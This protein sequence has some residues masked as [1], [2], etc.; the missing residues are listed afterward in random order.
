MIET[1]NNGNQ[2]YAVTQNYG[3]P[4]HDGNP[5]GVVN[6]NQFLQNFDASGIVD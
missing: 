2:L 5:I 1:K 4:L 3:V 6:F